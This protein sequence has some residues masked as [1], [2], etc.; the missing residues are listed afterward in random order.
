MIRRILNNRKLTISIIV[1]VVLLSAISI[2]PKFFKKEENAITLQVRKDIVNYEN[3]IEEKRINSSIVLKWD[4][5]DYISMN[6][7]KN[8][9]FNKNG[10]IN[11]A[12]EEIFEDDFYYKI[13]KAVEIY[14][15][16]LKGDFYLSQA[17]KVYYYDST[18]A[19]SV[20]GKAYEIPKFQTVEFED[21]YG[22]VI[23]KKLVKNGS[24]VVTPKLDVKGYKL[25]DWD[26][27]INKVTEDVVFKPIYVGPTD[28]DLGLERSFEWIK[29]NEYTGERGY[30][31]YVGEEEEIEI[32]YKIN[33]T[34]IT[35]YYKMFSA[36][37]ATLKTVISTNKKVTDMSH[38]FDGSELT[39][40]DLNGLNTENVINM[41]NMFSNSYFYSLNLEH[42]DTSNVKLMDSMFDSSAAKIINISSFDT[43]K[44]SNMNSMFKN[45]KAEILDLKKFNTQNVADMSNM[46]KNSKVKELN[47]NNFDTSYVENMS[48]MFSNIQMKELDLEEFN[49][50]KVRDM[51][52]MFSN[53]IF[54]NLDLSSFNT[55]N[56]ETMSNMFNN[57]KTTNLNLEN[58]DTKK[59]QN[60]DRMFYKTNN[61]HLNLEYFN[62]SNVKSMIE[63]FAY[64]E[65][66]T[67]DLKSFNTANVKNMKNMFLKTKAKK[68]YAKT[69]ADANKFNKKTKKPKNLNFIVK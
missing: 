39:E 56:V 37:P 55:A 67:L 23:S 34:E 15:P 33:G 31:L 35:S 59:V 4:K 49:T 29:E 11:E 68:G 61:I 20:T 12:N 65:M 69:Q 38:M 2:L 5:I 66:K 62:T 19:S 7:L 32:P 44:V 58:F 24:A 22:K 26:G 17:G 25:K 14:K 47:L 48:N 30:Y 9:M 42:F 18:L 8:T 40:I 60:M 46:F 52:H 27:N 63:M 16:K 28:A 1:V 13:P 51:S 43:S 10:L 36:A 41:S 45:S 21:Y 6:D 54:E 50:H 57:F 3:A 64:S 53:S